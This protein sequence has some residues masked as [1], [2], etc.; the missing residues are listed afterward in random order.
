MSAADKLIRQLGQASARETLIKSSLSTGSINPSLDGTA[1]CYDESEASNHLLLSDTSATQIARRS[2]IGNIVCGKLSLQDLTEAA[3]QPPNG[4]GNEVEF[5]FSYISS[6]L[7]F[8][9]G[10]AGIPGTGNHSRSFTSGRFLRAAKTS[11]FAG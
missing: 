8:A 5:Y 4:P 11:A 9:F 3:A 2:P 7:A 6:N 10:S 1:P